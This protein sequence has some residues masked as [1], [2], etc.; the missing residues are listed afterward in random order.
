MTG[1]N[2][3]ENVRTSQRQCHRSAPV[4]SFPHT[5][6]AGSSRK[7]RV[8]LLKMPHTNRRVRKNLQFCVSFIT[9]LSEI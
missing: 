1:H 6:D 5:E 2:D 4:I 8:D 3:H 7:I 9:L